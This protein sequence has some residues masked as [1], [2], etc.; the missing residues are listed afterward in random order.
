MV[1]H[2]ESV[3]QTAHSNISMSLPAQQDE[4]P[5]SSSLARGSR[6][7]ADFFSIPPPIKTLF[8]RVPMVVY[9]PNNLPQ[10]TPR[11]TRIPSLYV[12]STDK[13]AAAGRPSFNPSCLKWQTFMNIAGLDHRLIS[14]NNHASPSGA[15]PFLLPS[16]TSSSS[17]ESVLP[18]SSNKLIKYANERG[19]NVEESDSIRYEAYQSLIDHRIRNAWV[20]SS[21]QC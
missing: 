13:D 6:R 16:A 14:S 17:Q 2:N 4:V 15:L 19:A 21:K 20:S 10:R 8:D 12:F 7:V 18:I 9:A 3:R 5:S 11:T 1:L